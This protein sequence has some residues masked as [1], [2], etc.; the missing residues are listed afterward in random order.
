MQLQL[1]FLILPLYI[2][3]EYLFNTLWNLQQL[4]GLQCQHFSPHLHK[5]QQ[6]Q[7]LNNLDVTIRIPHLLGEKEFLN[8]SVFVLRLY[9]Q[10][11]IKGSFV[12]RRFCHL[13]LSERPL[14]VQ[15]FRSTTKQ[16]DKILLQIDT[17]SGRLVFQKRRNN[18][19]FLY[20]NIRLVYVKEFVAE[21]I[22]KEF[23]RKSSFQNIPHLCEYNTIPSVAQYGFH[24]ILRRRYPQ[25][26]EVIKFNGFQI[27]ISNLHS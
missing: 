26:L 19:P 8:H 24:V 25:G 15:M 5:Q 3:I 2:L 17:S 9:C 12:G 6:Q 22:L 1:Y 18:L 10:L 11:Y 27:Y 21:N 16:K 23:A 14:P 20:V 13:P 4:L 7:Q